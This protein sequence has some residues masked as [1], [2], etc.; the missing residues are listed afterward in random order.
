M[1][2]AEALGDLLERAAGNAAHERRVG[3]LAP[4]PGD[5]EAVPRGAGVDVAI[6]QIDT[7]Q[8]PTPGTA[9]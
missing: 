8:P 1:P 7:A 6:G 4:E 2:Y 5:D 3:Q 9:W